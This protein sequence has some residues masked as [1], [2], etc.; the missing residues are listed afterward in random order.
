MK[1]FLYIFAIAAAGLCGYNYYSPGTLKSSALALWNR[2]GAHLKPAHSPAVAD[3]APAPSLPKPAIQPASPI[4]LKNG[5]TIVGTI[6][7]RDSTSTWI[8]TDDGKRV[9][10]KSKDVLPN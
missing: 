9:E 1:R 3:S 6:I 8:R 10:V 7:V 2:A 5:K 4:R